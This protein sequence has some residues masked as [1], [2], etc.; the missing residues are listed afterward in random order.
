[1]LLNASASAGHQDTNLFRGAGLWNTHDRYIMD[2]SL[3]DSVDWKDA[4]GMKCDRWNTPCTIRM[5]WAFTEGSSERTD[6]IGECR[7][8]VTLKDCYRRYYQDWI[9]AEF[10]E[11]RTPRSTNLVLGYVNSDAMGSTLY[12]YHHVATRP[13][14]PLECSATAERAVTLPGLMAG[15]RTEYQDQGAIR[16]RCNRTGTANIVI[17][18]PTLAF[19]PGVTTT[20]AAAKSVV[21][22]LTAY[23]PLSFETVAA[24]GAQGGSYQQTLVVAIQYQ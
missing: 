17:K 12:G 1:M 4:E 19:A 14:K 5:V 15:E 3:P 13:S 2:M 21:A 23:V 8:S 20:V 22:D 9:S 7:D 10:G 6:E 18:T 16:V 24:A 11:H